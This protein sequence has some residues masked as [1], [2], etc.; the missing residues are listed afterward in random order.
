[1]KQCK[2]LTSAK[3]NS[4]NVLDEMNIFWRPR[5]GIIYRSWCKGDNHVW[6]KALVRIHLGD[7]ILDGTFKLYGSVY[8]IHVWSWNEKPK[9][10][11]L[12]KKYVKVMKSQTLVGPSQPT[13]SGKTISYDVII[14]KGVPI[15]SS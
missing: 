6:K 3:S 1:M 11:T 14:S 2:C 4:L 12:E 7:K 13:I 8:V 15:F 9:T 5:K 10:L